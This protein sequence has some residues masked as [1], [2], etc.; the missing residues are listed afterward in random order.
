MSSANERK[1]QG[2]GTDRTKR[3]A[4]VSLAVREGLSHKATSEKQ[5][6]EMG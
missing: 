5:C 3:G 6:E 2:I 1:K 4:I